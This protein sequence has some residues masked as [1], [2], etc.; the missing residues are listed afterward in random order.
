MKKA[1]DCIPRHEDVPSDYLMPKIENVRLLTKLPSFYKRCESSPY[2]LFC[3]KCLRSKLS[4]RYYVY[5]VFRHP[6]CLR[7]SL[8]DSSDPLREWCVQ[9]SN[10]R[11]WHGPLLDEGRG[12]GLL[13]TWKTRH[14]NC[15][16]V[17]TYLGPMVH[18]MTCRP[19]RPF[20]GQ[21]NWG[22]NGGFYVSGCHLDRSSRLGGRQV[23]LA[24]GHRRGGVI[25]CCA[26]LKDFFYL[27]HKSNHQ[28]KQI[29]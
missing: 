19:G 14:K 3:N 17:T 11:C 7:Q 24:P 6:H 4:V 1:H 5:L 27:P 23:V 25:L 26:V 28:Q 18:Q 8:S 2:Y 21:K 15:E 22:S 10:S 20:S 29:T 12:S 16:Q 9:F 13:L